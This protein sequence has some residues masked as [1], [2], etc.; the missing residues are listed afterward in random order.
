[1]CMTQLFLVCVHEQKRQ[2][3]SK[4][5]FHFKIETFQKIKTHDI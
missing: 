5:K 3:I 4:I 1:M 2:N